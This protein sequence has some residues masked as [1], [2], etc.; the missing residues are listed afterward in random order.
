MMAMADGPLAPAP[1]QDHCHPTEE[2]QTAPTLHGL[3]RPGKLA[4][5]LQPL[6]QGASSAPHP[7]T[8]AQQVLACL[9]A[10]LVRVLGWAGHAAAAAAAAPPPRQLHTHACVRVCVMQTMPPPPAWQ[11]GCPLYM[12]YRRGSKAKKAKRR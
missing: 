7:V 2:W 4:T 12:L 8:A 3:S 5:L 11:A 9:C 6:R 10:V 1:S